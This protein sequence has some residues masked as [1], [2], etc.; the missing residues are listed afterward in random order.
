MK[1]ILII[2][3]ILGGLLLFLFSGPNE[4]IGPEEAVIDKLMEPDYQEKK[5]TSTAQIEEKIDKEITHKKIV[6]DDEIKRKKNYKNIEKEFWKKVDKEV[7]KETG[8][9]NQDL[10]EEIEKIE[11]KMMNHDENIGMAIDE[12]KIDDEEEA[13]EMN[14]MEEPIF[15]ED[16]EGDEFYSS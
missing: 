8:L 9:M 16:S 12:S 6:N 5:I 1:N 3:L 4:Q 15:Q 13:E 2:G 11:E 10:N 14:Y 7:D